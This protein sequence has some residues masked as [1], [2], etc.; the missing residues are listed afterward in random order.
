[1]NK[2]KIRAENILISKRYRHR[3]SINSIREH[4]LEETNGS[5]HP[6]IFRLEYYVGKHYYC[7]INNKRGK[8]S[9][10]S[11]AR[12]VNMRKIVCNSTNWLRDLWLSEV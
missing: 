2:H 3:S 1:M 5:L 8:K 4:V 11:Q 10:I 7:P 9:K 6:R 12:L